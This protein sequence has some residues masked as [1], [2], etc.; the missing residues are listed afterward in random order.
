[1]VTGT[2]QAVCCSHSLSTPET[3]SISNLTW[4][5]KRQGTGTMTLC[6]V[7]GARHRAIRLVT[8]RTVR[9]ENVVRKVPYAEQEAFYMGFD[10]PTAAVQHLQLQTLTGLGW[11]AQQP[12][13]TTTTTEG[14]MYSPLHVHTHHSPMDGVA[15]PQ[16]YI[17]RAQAIGM[18][19]VAITD[20]GTLSGHREFYGSY[21]Y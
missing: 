10:V 13:T 5:I 20:H 17:E 15:T 21:R 4:K 6:V 1:M 19:S 8:L 7:T 18:E 16:E 14:S 2:R 11:G 3:G 9:S 12:P